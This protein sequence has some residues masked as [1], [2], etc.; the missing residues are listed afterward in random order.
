MERVDYLNDLSELQ[1]WNEGVGDWKPYKFGQ[2][3]L[4]SR[5]YPNRFIC[6]I[7]FRYLGNHRPDTNNNGKLRNNLL[8]LTDV[9]SWLLVGSVKHY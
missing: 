8:Q 6:S 4:I 2:Y 3:S 1:M 7:L 5:S 9:C